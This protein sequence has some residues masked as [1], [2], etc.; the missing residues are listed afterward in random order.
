MK[1]IRPFLAGPAIIF[2]FLSPVQ[3][4]NSFNRTALST[5]AL[6][7][8][9]LS[10][11]EVSPDEI[12]VEP[13]CVEYMDY[14]DVEI[15]VEEVPVQN[16]TALEPEVK[17]VQENIPVKAMPET[18]AVNKTASLS[19]TESAYIETEET[20]KLQQTAPTVQAY[21]IE[22]ETVNAD[23]RSDESSLTPSR[24]T[25]IVN[26][27]VK[28]TAVNR[29]AVLPETMEKVSALQDNKFTNPSNIQTESGV[30]SYSWFSLFERAEQLKKYAAKNGYNVRYA[31]L[32]DM[33]MKSGKKRM[34]LIDLENFQI[35]K[36]GLVAHGK[37]N[38]EFAADKKYSNEIGSKCTSLGIYK[39][40]KSFNGE[41][42]TAFRLYGLSNSNNNA[43]NRSIVLHS[44]NGIPDDETVVPITQTEGCPS[45][46]PGFLKSI[47]PVIDNNSRPV[48]MWLFDS[49]TEPVLTL[50]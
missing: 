1:R 31:F 34:F 49:R 25:E 8:F 13:V 43:F 9:H 24:E 18:F 27:D 30:E 46:S 12:P 11:G 39:I 50:K 6:S 28:N 21:A 7:P 32:A 16:I 3:S 20:V 35:L 14:A 4:T 5:M 10:E 37:G 33:G 41:F 48:L 36:S 42:G 44:M 29:E 22:K 17:T 45:L 2:L 38:E 26:V 23:V 19:K 47:T 15:T 40:G